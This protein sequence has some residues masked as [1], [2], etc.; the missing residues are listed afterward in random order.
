MA[1]TGKPHSSEGN[2][3][4]W[5]HSTF[6]CEYFG[7]QAA[8]PGLT[9]VPLEGLWIANGRP[10]CMCCSPPKSPGSCQG[11]SLQT[12]STRPA[13]SWVIPGLGSLRGSDPSDTA[14]S[15]EL[16]PGQE[17]GEPPTAAVRSSQRPRF[18]LSPRPPLRAGPG[19]PHGHARGTG[20]AISPMGGQAGSAFG[21]PG[22]LLAGP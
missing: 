7:S 22:D 17:S 6:L 18:P 8:L 12:K 14:G 5:A 21:Q 13:H 19:G 11:P 2:T 3:P 10:I 15:S 20:E 4:C 16:G 9:K 1:Q